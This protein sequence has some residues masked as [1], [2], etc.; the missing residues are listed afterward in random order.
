[1]KRILAA[2]L[3]AAALALAACG[4]DEY[5]PPEYAEPADTIAPA[6]GQEVIPG[7]PEPGPQ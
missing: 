1:M 3:L 5:E 2:P 6:P 7:E 4:G